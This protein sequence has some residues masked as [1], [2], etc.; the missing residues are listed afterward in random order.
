MTDVYFSVDVETDGP[1]P[2]QYASSMLSIGLHTPG[3]RDET[4]QLHRLAPEAQLNFY[5][6]LKPISILWEPDALKV[7]GLDRERLLVEG[8]DPAQAMRPDRP[9]RV[10]VPPEPSAATR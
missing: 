10:R 5:R 8:C 3:Y 1:I 6:E 4:G 2:G 9:N 7:S